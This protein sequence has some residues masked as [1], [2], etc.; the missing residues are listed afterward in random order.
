MILDFAGYKFPR[1]LEYLDPQFET[2]LIKS[3]RKIVWEGIDL[4]GNKG[5]KSIEE[6]ASA[7]LE[8]LQAKNGSR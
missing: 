5:Y 7:L 4:T 1:E 3:F 2:E 6:Y 8:K